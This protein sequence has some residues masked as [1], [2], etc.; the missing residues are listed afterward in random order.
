MVSSRVL[1]PDVPVSCFPSPAVQKKGWLWS[2]H[3]DDAVRNPP[4]RHQILKTMGCERCVRPQCHRQST[5]VTPLSPTLSFC[6]H[7][8]QR[9]FSSS[10]D[11]IRHVRFSFSRTLRYFFV[12]CTSSVISVPSSAPILIRRSRSGNHH[13]S[14]GEKGTVIV[15]SSGLL[16]KG[17]KVKYEIHTGLYVNWVL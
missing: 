12:V 11:K 9:F 1:K 5:I 16:R 2:C 8:R 7:G 13:V 10:S 14:L 6:C 3:P 17:S 4:C 15:S